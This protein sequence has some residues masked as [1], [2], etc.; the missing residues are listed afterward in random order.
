MKKIQIESTLAKIANIVFETKD[1]QA[2]Q[3][4]ALAHLTECNIKESDKLKM[5]DE[6]SKAKSM[7]QLQRYC[8][9][10]LLKYEGLGISKPQPNKPESNDDVEI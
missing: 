7:Y 4:A 5:I 10:A 9:N 1:F 2:A 8:A 6:V 3:D